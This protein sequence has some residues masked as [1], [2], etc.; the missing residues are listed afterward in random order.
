MEMRGGR[1]N[2]FTVE[3]KLKAMVAECI[4]PSLADFM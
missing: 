4:R 1:D 2:R 3:Q